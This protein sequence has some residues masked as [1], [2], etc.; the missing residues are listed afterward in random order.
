VRYPHCGSEK[1]TYLE[2]AGAWKWH[3]KPQ[4]QFSLRVGTL[5]EDSVI[6]L[7]KWLPAVRLVVGCKNVISSSYE[8]RS[9]SA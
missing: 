2:N 4:G 3:G 9:R 6:G 5:F 1:V 8:L 7:K